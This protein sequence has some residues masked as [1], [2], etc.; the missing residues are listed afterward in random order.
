VGFRV[1]ARG[2]IGD[3]PL[4]GVAGALALSRSAGS[5]H[6]PASF[7]ANEDQLALGRAL[8]A[9]VGEVTQMTAEAAAATGLLELASCRFAKPIHDVHTLASRVIARFLITGQGTST[10]E[11]NFIASFGVLAALYRLPVATL[12]S[13]FLLWRDANLR[14]LNEEVKRL[15]TTLA[16]SEE[17]RKIIRSIADTGMVG[18]ALAYDDQVLAKKRK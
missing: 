9:R 11:R 4:A 3:R 17:A 15:G 1:V 18:M 5:L 16:V 14:I 13:S 8:A 2:G 10:R 12:A 7:P 6:A